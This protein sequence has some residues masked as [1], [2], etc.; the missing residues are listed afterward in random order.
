VR[1]SLIIL[2]GIRLCH[3]T[4]LQHGDVCGSPATHSLPAIGP[5]MRRSSSRPNC[6]KLVPRTRNARPNIAQACVVLDKV[7]ASLRRPARPHI[8]Q[9]AMNNSRAPACALGRGNRPF[10]GRGQ[11]PGSRAPVLS[12]SPQFTAMRPA[13]TAGE[14]ARPAWRPAIR[15]PPG[16]GRAAPAF[17]ERRA[18][19][20]DRSVQHRHIAQ[21]P[22]AWQARSQSPRS[23]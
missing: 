22:A 10:R 5:A 21:S 14:D 18:S 19:L 2:A 9:D 4:P 3:P 13:K 17:Q 23:E 11:R 16:Q 1:Q 6:C 7:C 8:A 20:L 12:A 15:H